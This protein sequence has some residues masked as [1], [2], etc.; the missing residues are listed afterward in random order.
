MATAQRELQE[1]KGLQTGSWV[2]KGSGAQLKKLAA[3]RTLEGFQVR[4]R[5]NQMHILKKYLNS[6]V[7]F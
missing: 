6:K 2:T 1:L 3:V 5:C 4:P 7:M